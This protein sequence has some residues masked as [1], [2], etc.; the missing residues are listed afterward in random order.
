MSKKET[1]L[2]NLSKTIQIRGRRIERAWD[3]RFRQDI[4][5]RVPDTGRPA[6]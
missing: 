1:S 5:G 3:K 4:Y 2:Q 6:Y